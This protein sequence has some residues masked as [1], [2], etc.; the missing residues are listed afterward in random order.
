MNK[1][2]H[3][4]QTSFLEELINRMDSAEALTLLQRLNQARH[5]EHC[6]RRAVLL[7]T[8][9]LLSSMTIY[10]YVAILWQDHQNPAPE[11]LMKCAC[12]FGLASLFSMIAFLAGWLSNRKDFNRLHHEARNFVLQHLG[13]EPRLGERFETAF[14]AVPRLSP[15][16]EKSFEGV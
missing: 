16:Q 15:R 9:G 11:F 2:E 6:L 14:L 7:V 3:D 4:R 10:G 12:G 5:E 8:L 1:W 13:L